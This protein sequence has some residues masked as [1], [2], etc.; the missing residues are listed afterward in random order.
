[1]TRREQFARGTQMAFGLVVL[2]VLWEI[3]GRTQALGAAFPPASAVWDTLIAPDQR[4]LF[5]QALGTTTISAL[6]G[7]AG[8]GLI[9]CLVAGT[10]Q[11]V[12]WTNT[13]LDRFAVLVHAIP[14]V[15]IAPVL[16]L[17]AGRVDSPRYIA[18]I[19]AF[20]PAYVAASRAFSSAQ[21]VHQDLFRVLGSDRRNRLRR[22]LIPAAI[23]GLCDALRLAAPSAVLGAV[24]GEWFGAPQGIGV[25]IISSAQNYQID[26]LWAAAV[27]ATLLAAAGFGLFTALRAGAVRRFG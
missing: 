27:L 13:G 14:Q 26:Q 3:L 15:G 1:M 25:I 11:A 20:F 9:A 16:I 2:L 4:Y 10:G 5:Q 6:W 17:V 22:L 18:M 24:L 8:G 19:A 7:L 21:R 12:G 23:P